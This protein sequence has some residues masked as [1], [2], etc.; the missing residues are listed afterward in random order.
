MTGGWRLGVLLFALVHV[1]TATAQ[2]PAVD[3][4]MRRKLDVSQKILEAMVTS[5]WSDLEA[6]TRDLENL[7]NDPAWRVLAA[8]EYATHSNAFR[9]SLRELH[10]AA[11][12]RDL[13]ATPK[14]YFAVTLRCVECHRAFARNRIAE[15]SLVGRRSDS[16]LAALAAIGIT[17]H[18][19]LRAFAGIHH[20]RT[21][22]AARSAS[23]IGGVPPRR[24]PWT[25]RRPPRSRRRSPGRHL[26][27][28][29]R[30]ARGIPAGRSW[31]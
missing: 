3:R 22:L 20:L 31:C 26:D 18:L 15:S 1:T 24:A 17:A 12:K 23:L 4:V 5:R 28:R 16:A 29:L 9:Q 25:P 7:T 19:V 27:R 2:G 13:E 8:P 6:R 10:D 21:D 30:A 14:A 11:A